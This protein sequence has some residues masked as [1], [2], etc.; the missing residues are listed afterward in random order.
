MK[1]FSK[2]IFLALM[3]IVMAI[4]L[5]GCKSASVEKGEPVEPAPV[6]PAP[7]EPAPAEPVAEQKPAE[8][9]AEQKPAEGLKYFIG[10][11]EITVTAAD[12]HAVIVYPAALF[13]EA[14]ILKALDYA[15]TTYPALATYVTYEFVPGKL[16]FHYPAEWDSEDYQRAEALVIGYVNEVLSDLASEVSQELV[17]TS[18]AAMTTKYTLTMFGYDFSLEHV[19]DEV[20]QFTYP[21]VITKEEIKQAAAAAYEAYKDYLE[22]TVLAVDDGKATLYLPYSLAPE[23]FNFAAELLA[24][25]LKWYVSNV[26][27]EETAPILTKH[28]DILGYD[29]AITYAN[30]LAIIDYPDFITKEEVA[31]AAQL[32]Y[33][34]FAQYLEGTELSIDEGGVATLKFPVDITEADFD[35][36]IA[37]LDSYLPSYIAAIMTP[38]QEVAK[39]A[40][41]AGEAAA[42]T[43]TDAKA[44]ADTTAKAALEKAAAEAAA[45]ATT[46]KAAEQTATK[47]AVTETVTKAAE[48]AVSTA[49]A[50]KKSN[51]GLIIVIVLLV[52]AACAACFILLKKKKK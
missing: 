32:A 39:A 49:K 38:S 42:K 1:R 28:I 40:V 47:T 44:L 3:I 2:S 14:D 34:S 45:A 16:E 20:I 35:Y 31:A 29:T 11:N 4:A 7:V 36:A 37:L 27:E 10:E 22:G 51:V 30:R 8:K 41:D 15:V 48:E 19:A 24:A 26:L 43:E 18:T 5:V 21:E 13:T 52:L 50:Q 23:E 33:A 12:G 46:E 6:E 9:P 25:E 17:S